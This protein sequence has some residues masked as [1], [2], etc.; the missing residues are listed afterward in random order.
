MMLRARAKALVDPV[1]V[2]LLDLVRSDGEGWSSRT[3]R[4][5]QRFRRSV[6]E[7]R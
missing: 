6:R 3:L 1:K 2:R 5:I 4:L 7:V